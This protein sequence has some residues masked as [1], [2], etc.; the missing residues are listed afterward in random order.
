MKWIGDGRAVLTDTTLVAELTLMA[1][2]HI[3]APSQNPP[4]PIARLAIN[5][6]GSIPGMPVA[7]TA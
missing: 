1:I 7:V 6:V 5:L 3:A 2:E 4:Q